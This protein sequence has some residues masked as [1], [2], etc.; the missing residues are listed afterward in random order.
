L[1]PANLLPGARPLNPNKGSTI[2]KIDD[3]DPYG[4]EV[5]RTF[6]DQSIRNVQKDRINVAQKKRPPSNRPR[7]EASND[8]GFDIETPKKVADKPKIVEEEDLLKQPKSSEGKTKAL[9]DDDLDLFKP[10]KTVTQIKS[11][12]ESTKLKPED[13]DLFPN[14]S[15]LKNKP[16]EAKAVD[17]KKK[18]SNLDSAFNDDLDLFADVSLLGKTSENKK[19]KEKVNSTNKT[20]KKS[21]FSGKIFFFKVLIN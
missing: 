3:N 17:S 6:T 5:D 11:L 16:V 12:D 9:I 8:F 20:T 18:K 4:L 13:N 15:V 10:T 7:V 21:V 2:Q 1:N 19:E 14:D